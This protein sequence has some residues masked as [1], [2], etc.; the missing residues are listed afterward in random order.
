MG[1]HLSLCFCRGGESNSSLGE[2]IK[3]TSITCVY[4]RLGGISE[5]SWLEGNQLSVKLQ[6]TYLEVHRL[7]IIWMFIKATLRIK[8]F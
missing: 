1:W 2:L 4:F 8:I 3:D 7:M 6:L 5:T